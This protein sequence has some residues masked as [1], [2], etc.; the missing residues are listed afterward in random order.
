MSEKRTVTKLYLIFVAFPFSIISLAV[1][2]GST[3]ASKS[4]VF[5][6]SIIRSSVRLLIIC[7]SAYNFRANRRLRKSYKTH[8]INDEPIRYRN[9]ASLEQY[10]KG[11]I[12][13]LVNGSSPPLV[14]LLI[15]LI[16]KVY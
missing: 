3:F 10:H 7:S 8:I 4:S 16:L 9:I 11:S 2:L 6:F 1:F 13:K 14:P 15:Y 12:F 5:S